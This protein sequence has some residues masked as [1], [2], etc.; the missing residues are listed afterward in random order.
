MVLHP[1][2]KV[3][4]GMLV[5]IRIGGSQLMVNILRHRKWCDRK[6]QQNQSNGQTALQKIWEAWSNHYGRSE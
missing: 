6:E 2:T 5:T 1:L 3:C 4:I